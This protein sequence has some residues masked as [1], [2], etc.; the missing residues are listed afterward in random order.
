MSREGEGNRE[1]RRVRK[2]IQKGPVQKNESSSNNKQRGGAFGGFGGGYLKE[3]GEGADGT[4]KR[5]KKESDTKI[6]DYG[7]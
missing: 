5:K 3:K 2:H 6:L 7:I 4:A 1:G